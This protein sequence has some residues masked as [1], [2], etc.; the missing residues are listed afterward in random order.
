MSTEQHAVGT[1]GLELASSAVLQALDRHRV[2]ALSISAAC[3]FS[4]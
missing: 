3:T 2:H 1:Y 4:A